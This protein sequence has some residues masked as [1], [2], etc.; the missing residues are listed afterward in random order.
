LADPLTQGLAREARVNEAQARVNPLPGEARASEGPHATR[1]RRKSQ[2]FHSKTNCS[3]GTTTCKYLVSSF[4][5][6][7]SRTPTKR[8][9]P[10]RT[11]TTFLCIAC[12]ATA[13]ACIPRQPPVE[14]TSNHPRHFPIAPH[15]LHRP[16][17][18]NTAA[19][20]REPGLVRSTT[21][22]CDASLARKPVQH[23]LQLQL[24][25]SDG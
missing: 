11:Q 10:F 1:M 9:T 7:A 18:K 3:P 22:G 23:G 17:P 24:V 8:N 12:I 6:S 14:T 16:H 19:L 2:K 25:A 20:F 5:P 21:F 15:K 4:R 13:R